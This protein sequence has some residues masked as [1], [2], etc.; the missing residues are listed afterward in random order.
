MEDV[1]GG[2]PSKSGA[3]SEDARRCIDCFG[4]DANPLLLKAAKCLS[5]VAKKNVA[6]LR[7]IEI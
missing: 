6:I 3:G 7:C 4:T 5:S 1:L 2:A